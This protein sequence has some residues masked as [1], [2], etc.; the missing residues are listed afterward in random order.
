MIVQRFLYAIDGVS[1]WVGKLAAWL[2]I[3]LMTVVCVEVFKRYLLNAPT[4]W[5]F[6]AE[7]MLYGT[8]FMLCGAYTLAQNAMCAATFCTARCGRACRAWLDLV[9]YVVFFLP[10]IAA[11]IYAGYHYAGDPAHRR[12]LQRDGGRPTG[13]SVQDGHSDRRCL[14]HAARRCRDRALRCLHQNGE[15]PSRLKDVAEIDVVE[16][17]LAHSA[18]TS[19]RSRARLPSS[20]PRRST[21]SRASVAWRGLEQM[22]DPALGLLM[23]S[24][25]VVVIMMG[26]PTAF[27][28]MGLG[29]VFGFI[30]FYNPAEL[31]TDNRV[32]DLMVHRTYGAMTN[33]VLISI[34]LFVLMGYVM[35]RGALVDKMFY[36]IQLAFRTFRHRWQLPR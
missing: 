35:E 25:I 33:D 16:E 7:N 28:L 34:P 15:W 9:L 23:L 26:F 13:L 17:Q 11:L 6:D 10:G 5:I 31:W 3:A 22:S 18:N 29:I 8:L 19:M 4:A 36:S 12:A 32:F 20:A 27:T 21:R 1:T 24:L 2:I 14:G 30:A